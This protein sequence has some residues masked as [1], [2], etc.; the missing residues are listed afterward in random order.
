M[1]L[2]GPGS[3]AFIAAGLS[4]IAAGYS[5]WHGGAGF[6]IAVGLG[7]ISAALVYVGYW[8]E[9]HP[10]AIVVAEYM[11]IHGPLPPDTKHP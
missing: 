8:I 2:P 3:S 1:H 7:A 9:K 10:P 4:A 5:G 6:V 11:R